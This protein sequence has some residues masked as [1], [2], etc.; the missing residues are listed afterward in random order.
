MNYFS[1]ISGL[2]LLLLGISI[3]LKELFGIS[4][5]LVKLAIAIFLIYV[6]IS[7][8]LDLRI[9]EQRTLFFGHHTTRPF[10]MHTSSYQTIFGDNTL[11]LTSLSFDKKPATLHISTLFGKTTIYLD[12]DVSTKI[13]AHSSFAE[14]QLPDGST[15][16]FGATIYN[17][18]QTNPDLILNV[19][20]TFGQTIVKKK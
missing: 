13:I 6:G 20:T 1:L 18:H 5:P 12:P 16:A 14:I 17:S 9:K 8:I 4:I 2:F 7:L 15:G 3:F 10:D 11:D 19:R